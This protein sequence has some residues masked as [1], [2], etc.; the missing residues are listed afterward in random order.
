MTDV[1]SKIT[2]YTTNLR[3]FLAN[4]LN[5]D[6]KLQLFINNNPKYFATGVLLILFPRIVK[7]NLSA[8]IFLGE[9]SIKL[10]LDVINLRLV[11]LKL[12]ICR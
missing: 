1:V 5:M 7:K 9:K 4:M 6:N 2:K 12:A 8:L 11:S 3:Q 10:V